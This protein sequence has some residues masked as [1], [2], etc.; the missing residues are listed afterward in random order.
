MGF[1]KK[2]FYYIKIE[3]LFLDFLKRRGWYSKRRLFSIKKL[4]YFF[5][6]FLS[7]EAGIRKEGFFTNKN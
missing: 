4:K 3:I 1:E 7:V 6:I 5:G 2:A